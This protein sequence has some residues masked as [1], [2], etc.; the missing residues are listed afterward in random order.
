MRDPYTILG[1]KRSASEA[2]IKSAYRRLAK[3]L[4]PDRNASDPKAKDKFSE[5]TAAY[6][7]LGDAS[8]KTQFDRGEIDA[9]GKPRFRAQDGF[10]GRGGPR[11]DFEEFSFGNGPP[12]GGARGSANPGDLFSD[13]FT[14]AFR[15]GT[16]RGSQLPRGEDVSATLNITLED[17][18][19]EEKKRI[20]LPT[21]RDV[22]INLPKGIIDGQ[23]IRLKNLGHQSPFGGETGDLLLTLQILPHPLYTRDGQDLRFQLMID[24]EDAILGSVNRVQ[25]LSGV[26]DMKTPPMTSS[27]RTFRLKGKGLPGK[28]QNGDML[29]TIMIRLPD[30]ASAELLDYA[31]KKQL[32]KVQT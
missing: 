4:H 11:G 30:Q 31:R 17:I 1:L 29:V 6:E 18:A 16:G 27:G 14:T 26:V 28:E 15:G 2:E 13:L 24:L 7:I 19:G 22:D 3:Q 20:T 32:Q 9:E 12:R 25:T 21:G 23:I 8:K 10:G 5:L